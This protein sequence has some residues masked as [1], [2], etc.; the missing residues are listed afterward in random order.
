MCSL[1]AKDRAT[2]EKW[3]RRA[4][5]GPLEIQAERVSLGGVE[6]SGQLAI[7][8]TPGFLAILVPP[9]PSQILSLLSTSCSSQL[10][11]K[12]DLLPTRFHTCRHK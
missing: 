11:E 10:E 9:D 12:R 1:R 2:L 8:E 5:L 6:R 7:L 4:L 3:M